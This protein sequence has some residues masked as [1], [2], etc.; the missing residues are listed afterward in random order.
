MPQGYPARACHD[1]S[2]EL[3]PDTGTVRMDWHQYSLDQVETWADRIVEAAWQHGYS[4]VEFVHGASD[5][6]AR[7]SLGWDG[8]G[9]RRAGGRSSSCCAGACSATA[10]TGGRAS[11]ATGCTGSKRGGC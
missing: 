6:S 7:G 2:V 1:R 8:R 9:A 5:V 4:W 10:G 3:D 11:A